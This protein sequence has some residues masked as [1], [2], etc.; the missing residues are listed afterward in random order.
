M[1]KLAILVG[2]TESQQGARA[3]GPIKMNEYAWNRDLAGK[4][5]GVA[6]QIPGFEAR[7]FLRDQ[8]GIHGA[9]QQIHEWG[10]D[11]S[12]ELHF[13]SSSSS[14]STGSETLYQ[15][16]VS[17]GLALSVQAATVKVLQLRD[18]GVKTPFAASGGRGEQNLKQ[19][20]VRPSILTEPFFGSNPEDAKQAHR[21]K[22]DLARAQV[23]AA[24][25]YMIKPFDNGDDT[26]WTVTA[27]SLNVRG[28]PD[29]GFETLS[30]GPLKSGDQVRL[31]SRE[32][33]W[34]FIQFG[35]DETRRGY[36]WGSY[37]K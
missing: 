26:V 25:T 30:W 2:H 24:A 34:R 37:L 27:S 36:V 7:E 17:K 28:G 23:T 22:L 19:M 16:D 31:I 1:A 15:T 8:G 18:R 14:T 6:T 29:H 5:I 3:V 13:N 33:S 21:K 4:M 20:G 9:F 12:M 32:G 11:A 35:E 10:A